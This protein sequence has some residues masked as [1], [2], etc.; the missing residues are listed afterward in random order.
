MKE[1]DSLPAPFNTQQEREI[2]FFREGSNKAEHEMAEN[3]GSGGLK[4]LFELL[5]CLASAA[6]K[7]TPSLY[8]LG[9]AF[10]MGSGAVWTQQGSGKGL[11]RLH[12]EA[13]AHPNPR[14]TWEGRGQRRRD[15]SEAGLESRPC[16]DREKFFS[17]C[18]GVSLQPWPRA[19]VA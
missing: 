4:N 9:S 5:A 1:E 11:L 6:L 10:L 18:V 13:G 19:S 16:F 14:R 15:L 12:E 3:Q 7:T 17:L 8:D 2:F